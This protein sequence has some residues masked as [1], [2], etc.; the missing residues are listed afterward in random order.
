[1]TSPTVM[2]VSSFRKSWKLNFLRVQSGEDICITRYGKV[3]GIM[4]TNL[5][6][7]AQ[8]QARLKLVKHQARSTQY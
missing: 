7:T 1:M 2:S 8:E 3:Y 5:D 6:E 4:K